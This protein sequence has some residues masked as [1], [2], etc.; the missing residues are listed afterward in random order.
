MLRDTRRWIVVILWMS[1]MFYFSS[2]P[3]IKASRFDAVDF[4]F[5]KAAHLGEYAVLYLLLFRA[6]RSK[7]RGQYAFMVG[8]LYAFSDEIHQIFVPGRGANIR[9][10]LVFDTGGL[11]IGWMSLK[12][13]WLE[14]WLKR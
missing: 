5:K 1:L 8:L 10:I 6:F 11:I 4:V 3:A 9:D 12:I 13:R 14:K 7:M 2:M